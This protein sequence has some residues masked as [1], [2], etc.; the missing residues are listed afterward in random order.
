[1]DYLPFSD[2]VDLGKP[3]LKGEIKR[4][5]HCKDGKENGR[6]YIKKNEDGSIIAFCHHCGKKGYYKNKE[7]YTLPVLNAN[8]RYQYPT[9]ENSHVNK[10][11]LPPDIMF[12]IDDWPLPARVW[13]RK[14]QI[15]DD[16]VQKFGLGY[17]PKLRRV[18]LPIYNEK[19]LVLYQA[20]KLFKEDE[21]SKYNTV[22]KKGEYIYGYITGEGR[23]DSCCI[24]ED[25]LSG[26]RVSRF[27]DVVVLLSTNLNNKVINIL[28]QYQEVRIFLDN[29]NTQVKLKQ[30]Q[31]QRRLE[32]FVGNVRI[33]RSYKDPKEFDHIELGD[34][35]C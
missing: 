28:S 33:I 16:E 1:M 15:T 17:S 30:L 35:L 11:Y 23:S 7:D 19:G 18:I 24:V 27:T 14:Y 20:R 12:K 3:L 32:L 4:F 13:V 25:L 10:I 9:M 2:F 22:M 21:G 31:I 6:L 29:D 34:L 8:G 26:I 5:Y